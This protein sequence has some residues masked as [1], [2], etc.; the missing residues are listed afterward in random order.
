MSARMCKDHAGLGPSIVLY[1]WEGET[2][3]H[4]FG[5]FPLAAFPQI[6]QIISI[7]RI[8]SARGNPN[9]N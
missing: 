6:A 5:Y 8:P 7:D 2:T 1:V 9:N 4:P 3:P